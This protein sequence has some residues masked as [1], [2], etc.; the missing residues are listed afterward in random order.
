MN[1]HTYQN[2]ILELL[3]LPSSEAI[4]EDIQ[5]HLSTCPDCQRFYREHAQAVQSIRL[6]HSPLLSRDFKTNLMRKIRSGE[7]PER[8]APPVPA[9]IF[10]LWKPVYITALTVLIL[11]LFF[12]FE[13]RQWFRALWHSQPGLPADIRLAQAFASEFGNGDRSGVLYQSREIV[14]QPLKDCYGKNE[15]WYPLMIINE[16]GTLASVKVSYRTSYETKRVIQD[17][18]WY[19]YDRHC[20]V[21]TLSLN[22]NVFFINAYDENGIVLTCEQTP[23]NEAVFQRTK[24]DG[25][26]LP[27]PEEFLYLGADLS[28]LW[29]GG[30]QVQIV[31][32]ITNK[33]YQGADVRQVKSTVQKNDGNYYRYYFDLTL[34]LN[35]ILEIN[36]FFHRVAL[37]T[38]RP[39]FIRQESSGAYPRNLERIP[40]HMDSLKKFRFEKQDVPPYIRK[41]NMN[42]IHESAWNGLLYSESDST[43]YSLA[44]AIDILDFGFPS[45]RMVAFEY[46]APD[47]QPV[48][49]LQAFSI[50]QNYGAKIKKMSQP[51]HRTRTGLHV[52]KCPILDSAAEHIIPVIQPFTDSQVNPY[53]GYLAEHPSGSYLLLITGETIQNTHVDQLLDSMTP[54]N[55]SSTIGS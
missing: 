55:A 40:V 12:S 38:I 25:F 36:T 20:F 44:N 52:W 34:D 31:N 28:A 39:N 11:L 18:S 5:R 21:R 3:P 9:K 29:A 42:E 13:P 54:L 23:S 35:K 49:L 32:S 37:L 51:I 26:S 4:P 15:Q 45:Q 47:V 46:T 2:S 8:I 16:K 27:P 50:N 53:N 33:K 43:H 41:T 6:T 19:D 24:V 10:Q 30:D 48:F 22:Q 14:F 17:E 1:C 7:S